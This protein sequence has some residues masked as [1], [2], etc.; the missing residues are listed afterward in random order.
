MDKFF[1]KK[2]TAYIIDEINLP[3][4]VI[5]C[6]FNCIQLTN[7]YSY[8]EF[9]DSAPVYPV[10]LEIAVKLKELKETFTE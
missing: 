10:D 8:C 4:R 1:I 7:E 3:S 5:K 2:E 9:M 6:K